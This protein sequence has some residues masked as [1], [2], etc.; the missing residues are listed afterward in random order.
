MSFLCYCLRKSTIWRKKWLIYFSS[1][2]VQWLHLLPVPRLQPSCISF[3]RPEAQRGK[4]QSH[5]HLSKLNPTAH[6]SSADC[7]LLTKVGGQELFV[8]S[9]SWRYQGFVGI[10]VCP[11][12]VEVLEVMLFILVHVDWRSRFPYVNIGRSSVVR[13]VLVECHPRLLRWL[14]G[15]RWCRCGGG[16]WW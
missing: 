1:F 16:G 5:I 8:F 15:G 12:V 10:R 13:E 2:P 6:V 7:T 11:L 4:L 9:S 14:G 3:K